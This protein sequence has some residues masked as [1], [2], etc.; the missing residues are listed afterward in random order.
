MNAN[1]QGAKL[2]NA[3]ATPTE[4]VIGREIVRLVEMRPRR[5][6]FRDHLQ[7]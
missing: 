7:A 4:N 2:A 5:E 3:K 1:Q 6:W